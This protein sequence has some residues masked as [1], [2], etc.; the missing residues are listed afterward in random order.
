MRS[1][2][3]SY[4]L[5]YIHT[6]FHPYIHTLSWLHQ[7]LKAT[8]DIFGNLVNLLSS[9]NIGA[10]NGPGIDSETVNTFEAETA[11]IDGGANEINCTNASGGKA[12]NFQVDGESLTFN[13]INVSETTTYL[14]NVYYVNA[15][16]SNLKVT[17]NNDAPN[18]IVPENDNNRSLSCKLNERLLNEKKQKQ[19]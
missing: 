16:K 1:N 7:D 10:D 17:V 9:T 12:V 6:F 18:G 3:H 8:K 19:K 14:I 5:P 4:I 11:I 15:E 13:N 2:M